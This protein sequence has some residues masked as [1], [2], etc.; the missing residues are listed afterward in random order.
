MLAKREF[1]SAS[2]MREAL[3]TTR[4]TVLMPSGKRECGVFIKTAKS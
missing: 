2:S 3:T 4:C 1:V